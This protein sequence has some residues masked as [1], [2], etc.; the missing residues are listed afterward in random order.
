MQADVELV[1]GKVVYKRFGGNVFDAIQS[2]LF[3]YRFGFEDVLEE[4]KLNSPF[5]Y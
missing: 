3:H 4:W 1:D 2:H 5:K